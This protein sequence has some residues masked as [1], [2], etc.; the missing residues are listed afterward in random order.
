M[1]WAEIESFATLNVH[2]DR[3][4][5][6]SPLCIFFQSFPSSHYALTWPKQDFDWSTLTMMFQEQHQH[7]DI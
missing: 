6:N 2:L 7:G 5:V 3:I 1:F 4:Q